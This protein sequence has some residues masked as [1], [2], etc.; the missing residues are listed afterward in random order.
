MKVERKADHAVSET[1]CKGATGKTIAEWHLTDVY[2][3]RWTG[4]TLSADGNNVLKE[5]LELAHNGFIR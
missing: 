5:T 3:S 2:P 1:S 4:P